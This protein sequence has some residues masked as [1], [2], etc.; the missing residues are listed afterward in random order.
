MRDHPVSRRGRAPSALTTPMIWQTRPERWK[1]AETATDSSGK[2]MERRWRSFVY[3]ARLAREGNGMRTR[4]TISPGRLRLFQIAVRQEEVVHAE[5]PASLRPCQLNARPEGHEHGRR[6]RRVRRHALLP[7]AG[8]V[9]DVSILLQAVPERA[10]PELGLVVVGAA[11]VQADV[12]AQGPHVAQLGS[13]HLPGG[14]GQ[15][16]EPAPHLG[17]SRHRGQRLRSPD[18]QG[19]ALSPEPPHPGYPPERD[20]VVGGEE[21]MLHVG[22]EIGASRHGHR[23]APPAVQ[24]PHGLVDGSRPVVAERRQAQHSATSRKV[25]EAARPGVRNG[26][27]AGRARRHPAL[28]PP[29]TAAGSRGRATMIPSWP[30]MR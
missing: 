14:R 2:S 15:R 12:A 13:R 23:T 11:G 8:D 4:V 27:A 5:F 18:H 17:T 7:H 19:A 21:P 6:V 1:S 10:A 16:R 30:P 24:Q 20:Q 25:I 3:A 22:D 29:D 26:I 9:A 28:S